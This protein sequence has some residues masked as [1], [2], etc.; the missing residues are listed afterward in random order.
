MTAANTSSPLVRLRV[1]LPCIPP[2]YQTAQETLWYLGVWRETE[3]LGVPRLQFGI[4]RVSAELKHKTLLLYVTSIPWTV[5]LSWL[6]NARSR[7]LFGG[8]F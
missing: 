6:E 1:T 8:R 4:V 3:Q 7:P 5:R 2:Q